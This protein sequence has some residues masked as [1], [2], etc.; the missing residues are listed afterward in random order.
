MAAVEYITPD[1][2]FHIE[3]YTAGTEGPV[4]LVDY[5]TGEQLI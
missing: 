3:G 1:E 5:E 2:V 4:P